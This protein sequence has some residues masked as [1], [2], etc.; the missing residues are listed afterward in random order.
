MDEELAQLA[1]QLSERLS[2]LGV[3]IATAESCTGGWV[4]KVLTDIAGSSSWFERGFVT[5]SNAAKQE[6]LAV[7]PALIEAEGA[8]SET[9]VLEMVRGAIANSDADLAL[10]VSG[11]AGPG[12]G[13]PE[14]PVGTVWFA[15]GR[16]GSTPIARME[17]FDGD[18]DRVRRLAVST[19][20]LGVLDLIGR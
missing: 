13:T 10:A 15:W 14:K 9:V 1:L 6:M 4:A 18:R 5:Y 11:I 8:V 17:Q 19:A 7:P 16:S 12:G 3:T 2:S 20:L